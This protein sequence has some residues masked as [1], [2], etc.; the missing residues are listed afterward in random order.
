MIERNKFRSTHTPNKPLI[1]LL[2]HTGY[3]GGEFQ[4]QLASQAVTHRCVSRSLH[5]YTDRDTLIELIR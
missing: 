5:D 4:R 2:G 1:L 3:V